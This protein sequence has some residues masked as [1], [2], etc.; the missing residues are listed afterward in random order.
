VRRLV[1]KFVTE[2]CPTT[3]CVVE[4]HDCPIVTCPA[5]GCPATV[6][7]PPPPEVIPA[8]KGR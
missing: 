1:K 4:K 8:P 5:D 3:K 2:E 7:V 6:V